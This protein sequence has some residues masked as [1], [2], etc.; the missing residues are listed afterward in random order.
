[1]TDRPTDRSGA[2]RVEYPSIK[3]DLSVDAAYLALTAI[4]PGQSVENIRIVDRAGSLVGVVDL[5]VKGRVLGIE[6]L[7]ATE[8]LPHPPDR[9]TEE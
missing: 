6:F 4:S 2:E 1:L 8:R 9:S 5:D 7:E 3:W